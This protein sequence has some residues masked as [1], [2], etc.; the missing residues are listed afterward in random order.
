MGINE[1]GAIYYLPNGWKLL[2]I[3]AKHGAWGHIFRLIGY[4]KGYL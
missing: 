4:I 2:D 3:G 1:F